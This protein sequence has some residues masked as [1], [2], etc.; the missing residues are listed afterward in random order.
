VGDAA[1]M[2]EKMRTRALP[3]VVWESDAMVKSRE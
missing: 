1:Y 3:P 2:A